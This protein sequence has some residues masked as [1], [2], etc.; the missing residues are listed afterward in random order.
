M[1]VLWFSITPANYSKVGNTVGT[2]I[3]SLE[4]IVTNKN[5]IELGI[6]F[7][8]KQKDTIRF[9]GSVKYY[10]IYLKR[11]YLQ[12]QYDKYSNKVEDKLLINKF[13]D[14]IDDFKPEIIHVFGSEWCF[15]NLVDDVSV[16]IIIHIQGCWPVYLSVINSIFVTDW[17]AV[18]QNWYNPKRFFSY[19]RGQHK[20]Q[21]RA[22][23]EISIIK[24]NK[25]FFVRTRWDKAI[26]RLINPSARLFYCSEALR[27]PFVC[28]KRKW[29]PHQ[30]NKLVLVTVSSSSFIKGYD[31]ILKTANVLKTFS[32]IDFE[33]ILVGCTKKTLKIVSKKVG[34]S[35][36]AVGVV[37][38][39]VLGAEEIVSDLLNSDIYIHSAYIDNSPNSLCEAQYLGIP[40]ISTYVGGI[41]SLFSRNYDDSM[42]V[43]VNDEFY[44]ASMIMELAKNKSLQKKLSESNKEISHIRHKDDHIYNDLLSAYNAVL[45]DKIR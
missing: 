44:L 31:L 41:P 29:E 23:R 18:L 24:K 19:F 43:G 27:S 17:D 20:S 14:V 13:I 2:W 3:E 25:Y 35:Y 11:N 37:P 6:C 22:E 26:V 33:W 34:I 9:Q 12:A 39:G 1:R 28:S 16:P 8:S 4:R 15:G 45:V 30:R 36:G 40:I 21:E 7:I 42:L 5:D 32:S 10:P 38:K